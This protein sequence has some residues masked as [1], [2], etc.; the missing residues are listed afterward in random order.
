MVNGED[1][2]RVYDEGVYGGGTYQNAAT[3]CQTGQEPG[4]GGGVGAP[5]TG[6]LSDPWFIIPVIL[7]MSVAI[8][9][10]VLGVKKL[11]RRTKQR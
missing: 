4:T 10:I 9:A 11:T 7:V 1:C 3:E 2:A 6:M 8:A 5:N